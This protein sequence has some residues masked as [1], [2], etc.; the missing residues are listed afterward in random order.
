MRFIGKEIDGV[1]LVGLENGNAVISLAPAGMGFKIF[2]RILCRSD[3][4]NRSPV[5]ATNM[6]KLVA[7]IGN[8]AICQYIKLVSCAGQPNSSVSTLCFRTDK[9]FRSRNIQR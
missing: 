6:N 8:D 9:K 4:G 7:G 3:I 5:T 1:P 2:N